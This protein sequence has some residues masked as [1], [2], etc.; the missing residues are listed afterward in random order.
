[1]VRPGTF[2]D[3][4]DA[5]AEVIGAAVG[6]VVAGHRGDDHMLQAQ[7]GHGFGHPGRLIVLPGLWAGPCAPSKKPQGRVQT[8]PRIMKVAVRRA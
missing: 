2:A 4:Q 6:Q 8:L 7:A 1:M 5:T 3:S